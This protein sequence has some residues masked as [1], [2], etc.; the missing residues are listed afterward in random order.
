MNIIALTAEDRGG[1]VLKLSREELILV[2]RAVG[3]AKV[4]SDNLGCSCSEIVS[5]INKRGLGLSADVQEKIT[6]VRKTFL[7]R[8]EE[9]AKLYDIL[10]P[11]D[12]S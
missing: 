9:Y 11:G 2:R 4:L 6:N 3:D 10:D 1:F 8:A 7:D 5:T 12:P